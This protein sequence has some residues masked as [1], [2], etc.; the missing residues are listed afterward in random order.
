M[1]ALLS[2]LLAGGMARAHP[3]QFN[4]LISFRPAT[5]QADPAPESTS[6]RRA[7]RLRGRARAAHP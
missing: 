2:L 1:R 5:R 3:D 4:Q 6:R 7:R